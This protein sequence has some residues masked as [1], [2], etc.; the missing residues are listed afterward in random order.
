MRIFKE[1]VYLTHEGGTKFYEVA[2]FSCATTKRFITVRRWGKMTGAAG[3]G[4]V[5][6]EMFS[7]ATAARRDMNTIIASKTKRGYVTDT[8]N[9]SLRSG[10]DTFEHDMLVE[11]LTKHYG[12]AT[13]D[14]V[15]EKL[16]VGINS[17]T[18]CDEE[19][20]EAVAFAA[21]PKPEPKRSADWNSW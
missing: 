18:V 20:A 10:N 13:A 2:L 15:L 7:D 8:F 5:K 9:H 14:A 6:I 16:G 4:E 12:F 21:A 3:G 11:A 1:L 19:D 17:A